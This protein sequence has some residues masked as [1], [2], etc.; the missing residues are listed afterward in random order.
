MLLR[1]I[2]KLII[3]Y[4]WEN[5]NLKNQSNKPLTDFFRSFMTKPYNFI[6]KGTLIC[7]VKKI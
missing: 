6:V 1:F 4:L 2:R 3:Y 5:V 7:L